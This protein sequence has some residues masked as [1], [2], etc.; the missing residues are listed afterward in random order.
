MH[1]FNQR[2][3]WK[4]DETKWPVVRYV[5]IGYTRHNFDV[6]LYMTLAPR[7]FHVWWK[8][9]AYLWTESN[10]YEGRPYITKRYSGTW[11]GMYE[12]ESM[13]V[14]MHITFLSQKFPLGLWHG[15]CWFV[16]GRSQDHYISL[17]YH[18]NTLNVL[19][20]NISKDWKLVSCD[21]A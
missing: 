6:S 7:G 12:V 1:F 19:Y 18:T 11:Q 9:Y 4:F 2:L 3:L 5:V 8:Y 17:H 14:L 20:V 21:S 16:L 15:L 10:L 13:Y